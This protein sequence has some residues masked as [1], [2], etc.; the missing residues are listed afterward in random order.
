VGGHARNRD[1]AHGREDS[2][3]KDVMQQPFWV[4]IDFC[5]FAERAPGGDDNQQGEETFLCGSPAEGHHGHDDPAL[6]A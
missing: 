6:A 2:H 3:E 4:G 5:L 1:E